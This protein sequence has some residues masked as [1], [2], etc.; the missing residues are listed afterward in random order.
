MSSSD[1][2]SILMLS[3]VLVAS[4]MSN[5]QAAST[6]I[7]QAPPQVCVNNVCSAA[8]ASATAQGGVKWHPGNYC[9]ANE[10]ITPSNVGTELPIIEAEIDGCLSGNANVAGYMTLIMW[11]AIESTEGTY[12]WTII[13][14]IRSYIATNYPGKRLAISIYATYFFNTTASTCVP[15]YISSN[16]TYG[17]SPVSGQYGYWSI[18]QPATGCA[19]AWW[20]PAVYARI[21]ALYANLAART[22]PYGTGYTYDTDPYVEAVTGWDESALSFPTGNAPSDYSTAGAVSAWEAGHASIVS[23]WPHTN[24]VDQ[25]NWLTLPAQEMLVDC[26]VGTAVGGPDIIMGTGNYTWA[27]TTY[28]GASGSAGAQAGKCPYIAQVQYGD[29]TNPGAT[30]SGIFSTATG[31]ATGGFNAA[32]IWWTNRGSDGSAGAWASVLAF[33]NSNPIPS[34]NRACPTNYTSVRG[35]CNTQ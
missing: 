23:S 30:L 10:F 32:E 4:L 34:A 6:N 20:R 21:E 28:V 31:T 12:N 27:Q 8:S 24:V 7:P 16:S 14:Q 5:S 17:A 9:A 19:A 3:A 15:N 26:A 1:H 2:S 33:I 29:Y 13:D 22:S 25:D 11:P 18:Y 35:G